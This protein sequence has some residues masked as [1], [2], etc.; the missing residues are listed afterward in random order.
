MSKGG[1]I[2]IGL[3]IEKFQEFLENLFEPKKKTKLEALYELDSVIK[4]NFTIS[5]LEITEERLE[6]ISSKLNQIDI[7]T[8]DEIIVLIYS[9]VNSGIKSELIE[10]LKKN[11][12]LKKRLLDLIQFT[13]NKSNTLSLERNNIK[14][15]LQHML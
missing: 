4:T 12:S 6:V 13:E 11:P 9:C 8:L 5:I 3:L 10:R 15:S 1:A 14:N 7:R 2:A